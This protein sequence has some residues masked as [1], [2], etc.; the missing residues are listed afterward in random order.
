MEQIICKSLSFSYPL[1]ESDTLKDLSFSINKGE[2]VVLCGRSGCGKTT[3]LRHLKKEIIPAG[4][5]NGKILFNGTSV[6]DLGD[7]ES[8]SK[9]GFVMQNPES[10][11]VTDKVWHEL[12]FGLE[13]LG[14]DDASIR[15]KTAEMATYFGMQDWF[16]KKISEL[17]GG[18]KQMLNLAS[19]MVMNPEIIIFDE[20]TSQLD[21]IAAGNFL[22]AVSKI[23][24]ELGVTVVMTEHRLEEVFGYADRV[25]VMD[26]GR[27]TVDCTPEQLSEKMSVMDEFVRLSMPASVRIHSQISGGRSPITV[28]GGAAWLSSL[29][30]E[31]K[32]AITRVEPKKFEIKS[33]ALE[34]KNIFFRYEKD[35]KNILDNLS[36]NVPKGS[37]FAVMGG[38]AAGKSTLLKVISGALKPASGKVRVFGEDLKKSTAAVASMPQNAETLFTRKAVMDE[39]E[40]MKASEE[41]KAEIIAITRVAYLL[42]RHP[43]DVSGGEM[44]RIAL[45]KLLMKDP[46]ILLLDEPT[47]GMDAEFKADFAKILDALKAQGKTVVM[48]SHD[49][50]F[51]S[52]CADFCAMIFDGA[53]VSIKDANSFFA[54]NFFYT[55]SANR[56]SRHV[57]ENCVTDKDVIELCKQNLK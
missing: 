36:M 20:P 12:A 40:E 52:V 34:I 39:L 55:T 3:L 38:N 1:A 28:N 7:R 25:I 15:L 33:N 9:I 17:S 57:F 6:S 41:K 8:A 45:A 10:Q 16:D 56:M 54:G 27:I 29:F 2:F 48:V 49:I 22:S 24:R 23:N 14:M 5:R 30:G 19:V 31:K 4:K 37:V 42:D 43:Y 21:P 46:E 51:C 50:E 13:N 11:I 32:P 35:G 44:Q 18:K 26:G 53:A 47:K